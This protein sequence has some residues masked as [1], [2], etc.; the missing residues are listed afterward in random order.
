MLFPD[1]TCTFHMDPF[2]P[3]EDTHCMVVAKD[4]T[5]QSHA[6]FG[7]TSP[8]G[9]D[10]FGSPQSPVQRMTCAAVVFGFTSLRRWQHYVGFVSIVPPVEN[11]REYWIFA[12][13]TCLWTG[14]FNMHCSVSREPP[15]RPMLS[16]VAGSIWGQAWRGRSSPEPM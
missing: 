2:W 7:R 9:L 11:I 15:D 4:N 14:E 10:L 16:V 13:E 6:N 3:A 1:V 8:C 5:I 12:A